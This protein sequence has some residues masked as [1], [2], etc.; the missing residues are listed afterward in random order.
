MA[1][2]LASPTPILLLASQQ[3]HTLPASRDP[4]QLIFSLV[5][6][7]DPDISQLVDLLSA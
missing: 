4:R 5:F 1:S 3:Q 6:L 7:S 2:V